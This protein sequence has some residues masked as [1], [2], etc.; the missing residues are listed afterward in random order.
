[1]VINRDYFLLSLFALGCLI[2]ALSLEVMNFFIERTIYKG[3]GVSFII[4]SV[5]LLLKNKKITFNLREKLIFFLVSMLQLCFVIS[6]FFYDFASSLVSILRLLSSLFLILFILN[7]DLIKLEKLLKIFITFGVLIAAIS[8]GLF[9]FGFEEL[10]EKIRGTYFFSNKSII[11][12]QNVFGIYLYMC[13]ILLFVLKDLRLVTSKFLI[14]VIGILISY[15]KTTIVLLCIF[16]TKAKPLFLIFII[17]VASYY[18]MKNL[19]LIKVIFQFES[20][21][22][23]SGRFD[24]WA[25]A[26]DSFIQNPILGSS[27]ISIPEKSNNILQRENAFTTYHNV[28]MDTLVSGGVIGLLLLSSLFICL[29][30]WVQ[31]SHRFALL[32]LLLPSLFNTFFVFSPNILGALS[33]T[34]VLYSMRLKDEKETFEGNRL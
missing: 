30:S 20:A 14:L 7:L 11:F 31:K 32:M 17:P 10:G 22:T 6:I 2:P 4:L 12:E 27:E 29:F 9:V 3:L 34:F 18:F 33:A 16:F 24:L 15:Y 1:M 25:I 21:M 19:D 5:F 26:I 28:F 8:I 23:L 13:V